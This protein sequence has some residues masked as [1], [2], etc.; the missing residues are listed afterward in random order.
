MLDHD[1]AS[2]RISYE[3]VYHCGRDIYYAKTN[4]PRIAMSAAEIPRDRH[5]EG[6][7]LLDRYGKFEWGWWTITRIVDHKNR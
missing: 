3:A 7:R 4:S 5:N 6:M 2:V 1:F